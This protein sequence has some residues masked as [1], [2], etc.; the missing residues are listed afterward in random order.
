MSHYAAL[1][2]FLTLQIN[3]HQDRARRDQYCKE[4]NLPMK[5]NKLYLAILYREKNPSTSSQQTRKIK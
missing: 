5:E 4:Q 3:K 2:L 1:G